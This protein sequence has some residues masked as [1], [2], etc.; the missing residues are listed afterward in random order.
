MR[1]VNELKKKQQVVKYK[2]NPILKLLNDTVKPI[3]ITPVYVLI[4]SL[5]FIVNVFALHLYTKLGF[6]NNA[7]QVIFA[8]IFGAVSI[9]VGFFISKK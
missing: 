3:E 1:R 6:S 8:V 2:Q 7:N 4:I 9:I 5:L